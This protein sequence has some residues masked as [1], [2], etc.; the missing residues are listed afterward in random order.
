MLHPLIVSGTVENASTLTRMCWT[1][2]Y[3]SAV[4]EGLDIIATKHDLLRLMVQWIK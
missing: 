1:L 3:L 2:A 4:P